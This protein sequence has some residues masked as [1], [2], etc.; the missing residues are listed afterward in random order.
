[1][2]ISWFHLMPYRFLP[3]DFEDKYPSVWVD[4]PSHLFEANKAPQL[5]N[6]YLD[7]LEFAD[8][9]GFDGICVNEHHNNAYGIMPSPNIT[10]ATLTRRTSNAAIIV[11]GNSLALY[12]PPLRVAEEFAMLD[13]ISGGRLVAGFPVGT[14]MD[15]NFAY[16]VNPAILREKYYEAHDLVMKAWTEPDMFSFNGK[17]NQVRYANI[18]PRPLQKPHPPVWIPGGG[19]VETW[20][21]TSRMNY[22]YCYLSY[23]GYKRGIQVMDGFWNEMERLGTDDNPYRAGFLQLVCVAETDKKAKELYAEHVEYFYKKCLHVYE[24]FA[25]AP[26]Y[27]TIR[28]LKAGAVAQLGAA[29]NQTRQAMT[30]DDFVEQGYVIAGS[31][32]TVI[33]NLRGAVEGLRVGHLMVLLQIGSMPKDLTMKNTELFATEV[34]P[35][36][37]GMWDEYEDHWWP[38]P[39]EEPEVA[40][41]ASAGP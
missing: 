15:T 24:G 41:M 2:K 14:S 23:S 28:T 17:Y 7:E 9:V 30:W 11:L 38:Q 22:V 32:K 5:Y 19:S 4:V 34:Y 29:A 8:E 25:D 21:W 26:G 27:R 35:E 1:M 37:Q 6:E 33:E 18:W 31:P 36:L 13:C 10:A 16:G 12:N 20:E 40:G 3:K 39:I